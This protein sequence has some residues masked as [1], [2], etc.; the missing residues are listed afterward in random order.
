MLSQI[1]AL[2][3]QLSHDG[4]LGLMLQHYSGKIQLSQTESANSFLR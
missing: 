2:R 4:L 3:P 1:P